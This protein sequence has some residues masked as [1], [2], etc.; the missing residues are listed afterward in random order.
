MI[1]KNEEINSRET[2][3]KKKISTYNTLNKLGFR[4]ILA[5]L[6]YYTTRCNWN[7]MR[8][9]PINMKE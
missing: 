1:L 6:F 2:D 4:E 3:F 5:D 9:S 7:R 8:I